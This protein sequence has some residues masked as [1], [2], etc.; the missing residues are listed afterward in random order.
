ML[1]RL[2]VGRPARVIGADGKPLTLESLPARDARWSKKRKAQVV[3][4]VRGNLI[5]FDEAMRRYGLSPVEFIAWESEVMVFLSA[6]Q[7]ATERR[8]FRVLRRV[9]SATAWKRG[10]AV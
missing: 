3:A 5:S 1:E 7:H 9:A 4:A 8:E 6:R 2:N 10:E